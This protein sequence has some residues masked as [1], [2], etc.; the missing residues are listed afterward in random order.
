[1][2]VDKR[3]YYYAQDSLSCTASNDSIAFSCAAKLII[4][5]QISEKS[6][7]IFLESKIPRA[8]AASPT[9]DEEASEIF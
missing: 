2:S 1:M 9:V 3:D 4:V 7:Q 8:S 5:S 6:S